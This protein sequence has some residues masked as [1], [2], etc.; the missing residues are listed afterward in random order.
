MNILHFTVGRHL[1]YLQFLVTTNNRKCCYEQSQICLILVNMYTFVLGK[2]LDV[3]SL[4]HNVCICSALVDVASFLKWLYQELSESSS[5]S[6][7]ST[8]GIVY[9]LKTLGILMV[10][11]FYPSHCGFNLNF[12]VD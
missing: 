8:I 5:S 1:G 6:T 7:F 11:W 3:K 12:S 4:G 2:F 9:L 10:V